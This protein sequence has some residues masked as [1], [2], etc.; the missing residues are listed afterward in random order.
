MLLDLF[1]KNKIDLYLIITA[2]L[3]IWFFENRNFLDSFVLIF[4]RH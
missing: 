3:P 1:K 4:L 2:I